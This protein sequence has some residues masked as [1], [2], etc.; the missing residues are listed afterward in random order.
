MSVVGSRALH[1][2]MLCFVGIGLPSVVANLARHTHAPDLTLIY[3]SGPIGAR[4]DRLPLSIGDGILAATSDV[5]VPMP[6]MFNYWLQGGHIDMGYL[7]AAQIDRYGNINSTIIG[8]DYR[9]PDVRLPGAG[10]APEIATACKETTVIVRHRLRS[11]VDEVDFITTVGFGPS[12]TA[13]PSAAFPGKGPTTVITDLGVLE[14][15][16]EDRELTLVAVHPGVTVED[17]RK[18]T[19]WD[20]RISDALSETEAPTHDE[21]RILRSLVRS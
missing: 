16:P 7:G 11:F 13:R 15:D 14:P 19:G 3:E 17:V 21:L 2:G 20:L 5:V 8:S 9:A 1:N 12:G 10:G 6:E 4:P 18:Q